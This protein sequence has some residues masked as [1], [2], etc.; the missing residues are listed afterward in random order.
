MQ[1]SNVL[2]VEASTSG[3]SAD[4]AGKMAKSEEGAPRPPRG[5]SGHPDASLREGD[6]CP[7]RDTGL[8]WQFA[9][10]ARINTRRRRA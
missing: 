6:E 1:R 3:R 7:M 5:T 4:S 2:S 9:P 8:C 10:A